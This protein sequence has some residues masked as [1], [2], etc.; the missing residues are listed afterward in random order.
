[1]CVF[2]PYLF[3]I[4]QWSFRVDRK[5]LIIGSGMAQA[6]RSSVKRIEVYVRSL[7][8]KIEAQDAESKKK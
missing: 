1:M 8:E 3:A 4:R 5:G 7:E 6:L 2:P